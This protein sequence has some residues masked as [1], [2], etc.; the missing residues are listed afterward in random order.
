MP[1]GVGGGAGVQAGQHRGPRVSTLHVAAGDTLGATTMASVK[2]DEWAK[3]EGFR[4]ELGPEPTEV[5]RAWWAD[6]CDHDDYQADEPTPL[7]VLEEPGE[8]F[9]QGEL[10]YDRQAEEIAFLDSLTNGY[11]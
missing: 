2:A 9:D 5:D 10:D 3:F 4:I 1:P 7:E 11:G 6:H 8:D